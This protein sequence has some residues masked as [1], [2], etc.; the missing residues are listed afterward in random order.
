[1]KPY[2]PFLFCVGYGVGSVLFLPG[3][4]MTFAIGFT[5][6]RAFNSAACKKIKALIL[7]G[8]IVIGAPVIL[9]G[10]QFCATV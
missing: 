8:A 9:I 6:E 5:F 7:L 3:G 4:L 10:A 2:G 1:M